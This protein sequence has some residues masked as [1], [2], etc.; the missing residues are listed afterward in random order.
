VQ[1][2]C[3]GESAPESVVIVVVMLG[4]AVGGKYK[5]KGNPGRKGEKGKN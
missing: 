4:S 1:R 5:R 2:G 3:H